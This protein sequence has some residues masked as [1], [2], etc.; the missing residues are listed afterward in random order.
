[1]LALSTNLQRRRGSRRSLALLEGCLLSVLARA[2]IAQPLASWDDGSAKQAIVKFVTDV[3]TEGAPTFLAPSDRIAVFDNDGT[4]WSEQPLYFQFMFV[5][6]RIKAMAPQHPEWKER[7]PFKS[8]LAGDIKTALAGGEKAVAEMVGSDARR[9]DDRRVR[10]ASG[11]LA[12]DGPAIP[13][14]TGRIPISSFIEPG[15]NTH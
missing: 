4:L 13:A 12:R 15:W 9:H 10:G 7:E 11:R 6:D 5:L 14:S 3:S 2:S 1:M 8:I